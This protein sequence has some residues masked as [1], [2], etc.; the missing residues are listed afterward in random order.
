MDL[1]K[2][3]DIRLQRKYSQ[4]SISPI[5][6]CTIK[7]YREKESGDKQF[8]LIEFIRIARILGN[9]VLETT[10][11]KLYEASLYEKYTDIEIEQIIVNELRDYRKKNK[12]TLKEMTNDIDG[13]EMDLSSYSRK[14]KLKAPFRI[15]EIE[16]YYSFF[17]LNTISE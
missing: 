2:Y 13:I 15:D 12:L 5:A 11:P 17:K 1:I 6:Q 8:K 7:N 3:K 16:A 14:E 9:E 10:N 4:E